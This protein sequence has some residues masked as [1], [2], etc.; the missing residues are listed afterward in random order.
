MKEMERS[1]IEAGGLTGKY[2]DTKTH[3]ITEEE[4]RWFEEWKRTRRKEQTKN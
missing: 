3:N 2:Y 1:I 4:K